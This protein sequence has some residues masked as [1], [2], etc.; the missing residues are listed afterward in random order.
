MMPKISVIIPI[1]NA[2]KYIGEC[3]ESIISQKYRDFEVIL[4]DDGSKDG[5]GIICDRYVAEDSRFKVIHQENRGISAARNA[6]LE[7]ARGEYITFVDSDDCLAKDMFDQ[8]MKAAVKYDADIV[9]CL[10]TKDKASLDIVQQGESLL[11]RIYQKDEMY[12]K[13]FARSEIDWQY[14]SVWGKMYKREICKGVQFQPGRIE[15]G[16]LNCQ[17]FHR[18]QRIVGCEQRFYYWRQ[19]PVSFSHK[20]FDQSRIEI[21]EIYWNMYTYLA[22]NAPEMKDY[23]LRKW[24]RIALNI[25]YEAK[26]YEEYR[27]DAKEMSRQLKRRK[28]LLIKNSKIEIKEKGFVFL[29][30]YVEGLYDW[31]RRRQE[32]N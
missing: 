27:Q 32:R 1:Y 21:G 2:E 20:K 14:L 26:K 9:K 30:I 29:A 25:R 24:F 12:D 28:G 31:F 18:A 16:Q 5:S 17:V 23:G 15:D 3:I 11:W 8:W 10:A 4:V 22:D 7:K 13:L 6:G 19:N